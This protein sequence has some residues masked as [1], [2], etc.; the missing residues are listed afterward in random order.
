[1]VLTLVLLAIGGHAPFEA[2]QS[3]Q[4]CGGP[5]HV[6]FKIGVRDV[7]DE[8]HA[9]SGVKTVRHFLQRAPRD[10]QKLPPFARVEPAETFNNVGRDG[11]GSSPKLCRQAEL[12]VPRE[13]LL[14]ELVHAQVEVVR[15]LP[16]HK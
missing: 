12:L 14:R 5:F 10:V 15:A 3:G 1:M 11:V 4:W 7:V 16:G 13:V 9:V 6:R 8:A 2:H